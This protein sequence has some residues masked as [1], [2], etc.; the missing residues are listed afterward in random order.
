MSHGDNSK[1]SIECHLHKAENPVLTH[2]IDA[3]QTM[4]DNGDVP[5]NNFFVWEH[6]SQVLNRNRQ[7]LMYTVEEV[8]GE[9]VLTNVFLRGELVQVS[10]AEELDFN[11]D[12]ETIGTSIKND[13]SVDLLFKLIRRDQ[14]KKVPFDVAIKGDFNEDGQWRAKY[15]VDEENNLLTAESQGKLAQSPYKL[16]QQ[17]MI[18]LGAHIASQTH[19]QFD[20]RA[21]SEIPGYAEYVNYRDAVL[22]KERHNEHVTDEDR[23]KELLAKKA[24]TTAAL[25]WDGDSPLWVWEKI[26]RKYFHQ[27]FCPSAI[28]TYWKLEENIKDPTARELFGKIFYKIL[29]GSYIESLAGLTYKDL[30]FMGTDVSYAFQRNKRRFGVRPWEVDYFKDASAF[31]SFYI[32]VLVVAYIQISRN[33]KKKKEKRTDDQGN[34]LL[35]LIVID[36]NIVKHHEYVKLGGHAAIGL[37]AI[38]FQRCDLGLAHFITYVLLTNGLFLLGKGADKGWRSMSQWKN[39]NNG[40]SINEQVNNSP[41]LAPR[42]RRISRRAVTGIL[43]KD[44]GAVTRSSQK[45]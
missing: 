19:Q 18:N 26:G 22:V 40:T 13:K 39:K 4:I 35:D 23:E 42:A 31:L 21:M 41:G 10:E 6:V 30:H 25:I 20:E 8:H 32:A 27:Q 11:K 12:L 16:R 9:L 14:L 28:R 17:I 43:E 33:P 29:Y 5:I 15:V 2:S 7:E 3:V 44:G 24:Y 36:D 38:G 34:D 45:Q 1:V 37:G